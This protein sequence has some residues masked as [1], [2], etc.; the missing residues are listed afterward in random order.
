MGSLLRHAGTVTCAALAAVII[1][2]ARHSQPEVLVKFRAEQVEEYCKAGII[3]TGRLFSDEEMAAIRAGLDE[4]ISVATKDGKVRSEDLLNLHFNDTWLLELASHPR[5]LDL[6]SQLLDSD[7]VRIFT[8]RILSKPARTGYAVPWHQDSNYW[9]LNPLRVTSLWLAVDDADAGNGAMQ[10]INFTVA[11]TA[12]SE[13]LPVEQTSKEGG[14]HF[15]LNIRQDA[16][17]PYEDQAVTLVLKRGEASFH[18]AWLPH[19]SP[20][21]T[22]S[23]R[24]CAWI[25]RYTPAS[26]K[27]IPGKRKLFGDDYEMLLVR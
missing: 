15:D 8:T 27:L 19:N 5:V 6:A 16:I 7:G 26:T 12:R 13:N 25:V 20:P 14:A 10:T 23:R 4:R 3:G 22:S 1:W 9:P 18:D 17:A 21:N 11:P 2:Q 24:R